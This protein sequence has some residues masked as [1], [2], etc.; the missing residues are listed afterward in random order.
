[1]TP[2]Y[3]GQLRNQQLAV[4]VADVQD[5]NVETPETLVE[6]IEDWGGSW[7]SSEQTLI[8]SSCGMNHLPR[9]IAYGK[10]EAMAKARDILRG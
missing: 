8:T 1:M 7:L 4:G 9:E 6:R 10:L 2:E 5:M 3:E